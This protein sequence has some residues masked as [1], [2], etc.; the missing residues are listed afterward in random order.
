VVPEHARGDGAPRTPRARD[1]PD[2]IGVRQCSHSLHFA[3]RCDQ[4]EVAARPDIGTAQRHQQIDVGGPRTD[5]PE[6]DERGARILIVELGEA[7]RIE[8][9]LHDRQSKLADVVALLPGLPGA[10]ERLLGE[11]GDPRGSDLA[12]EPL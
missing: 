11:S 6:R 12:R 2:A 3:H 8:A 10:A 5:A 1:A 7:V 4:R 9:P